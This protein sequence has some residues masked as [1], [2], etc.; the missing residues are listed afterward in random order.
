MNF[1]EIKCKC[2]GAAIKADTNF[3][4]LVCDYCGSHLLLNKMQEKSAGNYNQQSNSSNQNFAKPATFYTSVERERFP[5]SRK[6]KSLLLFI[7]LIVIF[8]IVFIMIYNDIFGNFGNSEEFVQKNEGTYHVGANLKAGEYLLCA[9]SSNSASCIISKREE[10]IDTSDIVL[11]TTFYGR[12]YVELEEGQWIKISHANLFSLN[13]K[14]QIDK[15]SKGGYYEGQYKAGTDIKAGN[16][17]IKTE[18]L[19]Y[20]EITSKPYE[21]FSKNWKTFDNEQYVTLNEGDYLY[22]NK[23]K[24]YLIEDV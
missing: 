15:D 5:K 13:N 9:T 2:C 3:T 10:P 11:S 12:H 6:I 24:L 14:P 21:P 19:S 18:S 1:V 8:I 17:V 7:I 20:Y 22:F 4:K 16:Y 23:G